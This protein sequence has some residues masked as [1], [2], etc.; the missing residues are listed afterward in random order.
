MVSTLSKRILALEQTHISACV[1]VRLFVV[2]DYEQ[3]SFSG[4]REEPHFRVSLYISACTVDILLLA[5]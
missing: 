1:F 3:L 5:D 2:V 4:S